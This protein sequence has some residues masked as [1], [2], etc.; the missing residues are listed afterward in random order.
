MKQV[1]LQELADY[2]HCE[3]EIKSISD[4]LF[5][6]TECGAWISLEECDERGPIV[7][8]GSIIEGQCG[9]VNVDPYIPSEDDMTTEQYLDMTIPYIEGEVDRIIAE[10]EN[11]Q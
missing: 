7:K 4:A 5:K 2:F 6:S 9:E 3:P 11:E 8:M 1:I 10:E